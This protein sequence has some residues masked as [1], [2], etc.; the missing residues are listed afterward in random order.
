MR[1]DGDDLPSPL[2]LADE[3]A[4]A[5]Q[6]V[7]IIGYP[8]FDSRN[9]AND[10]ARYVHDLYD[11]KRFAPGKVMQALSGRTTLRHDCATLGGN[12]GS[13]LIRLEDK[14]VVG[15][16]FAGV[17]GRENSAVG[18]VTLRELIRGASRPVFGIVTVPRDGPGTEA[19]ADGFHTRTSSRD[20]RATTKTSW[21]T[22]FPHLGPA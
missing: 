9:D 12:S 5:D 20:G 10:Q 19:A 22:A 1:I 6:V 17:Y 3:G 18:A 14:K 11:V 2:P 21:V 16:H 15:L 7:A 8:A 4:E 13:P